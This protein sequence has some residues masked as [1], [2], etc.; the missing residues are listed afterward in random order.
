MEVTAC[1]RLESEIQPPGLGNASRLLR[2][3]HCIE[4]KQGGLRGK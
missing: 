2:L 1:Q 3:K 4:W